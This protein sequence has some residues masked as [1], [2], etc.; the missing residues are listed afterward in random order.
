MLRLNYL[1]YEVC[2]GKHRTINTELEYNKKKEFECSNF[3][4][5]NMRDV[6]LHTKPFQSERKFPLQSNNYQGN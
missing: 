2:A 3:Q 1:D 5:A 6:H 4:T